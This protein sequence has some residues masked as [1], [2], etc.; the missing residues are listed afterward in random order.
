MSSQPGA[1]SIRDLRVVRG[2]NV[3][4]PGLNAEVEAGRITGL[5][6][7]SGCGKST[8]MRSVVGVQQVESGVVTVL[9]KPAGSAELRE[10]VGYVTQQPSV[11]GD[12]TADQN[13]QF[14]AKV[15]DVGDE[16][17]TE[18]LEAV[19]MTRRRSQLVGT[20]SG[21]Q[22]TRIS[23]ATALLSRPPLLVLDEPTVGLDPV[24]REG[25][26]EMFE[27]VVADGATL[28]VSSH[29]MDEAERC[30]SLMLMREGDLLATG[31]PAEMRER[32]GAKDVGEAFL[33]MIEARA[34]EEA[35]A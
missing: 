20:M 27:R 31:S 30:H 6:G 19:D 11:Y 34:G 16:R 21:G 32:T 15:L 33:R 14:F 23:L 9:G 5:L 4:L 17:I 7:P 28:L 2:D 26:W 8:F 25:L 18:A 12:L 29:V 3:V 10:Q 13:L 22:R 24:L 35:Q 1:I